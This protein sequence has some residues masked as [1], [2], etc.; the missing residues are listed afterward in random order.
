MLLYYVFGMCVVRAGS[1]LGFS[2]TDNA[3]DVAV[4]ECEL[5]Q[6]HHGIWYPDTFLY[7]VLWR[8]SCASGLVF[9]VSGTASANELISLECELW[10]TQNGI[11]YPD[12]PLYCAVGMLVVRAGSRSVFRARPTRLI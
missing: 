10:Q 9:G 3:K 7:D 8:V 4:L 11:W 5:W 12:V 1:F 6:T 2:G